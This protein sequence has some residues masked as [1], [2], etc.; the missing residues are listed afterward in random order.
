MG[1]GQAL[2]EDRLR[3]IL[4]TNILVAIEGDTLTYPSSHRRHTKGRG[5]RVDT[6]ALLCSPKAQP[7]TRGNGRMRKK[8]RFW[9]LDLVHILKCFA[10]I[11]RW[12]IDDIRST[13]HPR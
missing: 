13:A 3:V 7:V 5:S 12:A 9:M 11:P 4:D 1:N 10:P 8:D 2:V 6:P